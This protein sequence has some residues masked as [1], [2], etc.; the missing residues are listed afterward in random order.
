[1]TNKAGA[2]G[3][4][5]GAIGE[6]AGSGCAVE[7]LHKS[8]KDSIIGMIITLAFASIILFLFLLVVESI[9]N[10]LSFSRFSFE[11]FFF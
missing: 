4:K 10:S 3:E 11:V 9:L 6:I 1:M 5:A 7:G 2:R 8:M